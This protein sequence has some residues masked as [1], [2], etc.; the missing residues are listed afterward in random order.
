MESWVDDDVL[1]TNESEMEAQPNGFDIVHEDEVTSGDA[2][3]EVQIDSLASS[4][5]VRTL[6]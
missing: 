3:M 6:L 5:S 4:F 1:Y 2:A